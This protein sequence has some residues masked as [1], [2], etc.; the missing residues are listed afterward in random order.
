MPPPS[1]RSN[2]SRPVA[3]ARRRFDRARWRGTR[4]CSAPRAIRSGWPA[5]RSTLRF[6][7]RVPGVAGRALAQPF[8]RGG[9]AFAADVLRLRLATAGAPGGASR[10]ERT[11]RPA[12]RRMPAPPSRRTARRDCAEQVVA[13]GAGGR[14]HLVDADDVAPQLHRRADPRLRDRIDVH[15]EHVHRD[16]ADGAGAHAGDRDR[17]TAS[18]RGAGSRR[19]SRS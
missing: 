17:R 12:P 5:A 9:A 15:G 11:H 10:A 16:A 3:K 14:R 1:T 2:S 6:V 13:D 19:H 18:A 7:E 4:R 8:G